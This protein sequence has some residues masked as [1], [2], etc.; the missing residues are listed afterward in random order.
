MGKRKYLDKLFKIFFWML[1][2]AFTLGVSLVTVARTAAV[3]V[4]SADNMTVSLISLQDSKY[5]TNLASP[6]LHSLCSLLCQHILQWTRNISRIWTPLLILYILCSSC[7]IN[8]PAQTAEYCML[9]WQQFWLFPGGGGG[10]REHCTR[11][12][13]LFVW[14]TRKVKM[15]LCS[16]KHHDNKTYCGAEIKI[17][18]FLII[19]VY[20]DEWS[21]TRSGLFNPGEGLLVRV[22]QETELACEPFWTW[23]L[24]EEFLP[25]S[26]IKPQSSRK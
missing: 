1:C 15:S 17:H 16:I 13:N 12:N 21:I 23:W 4:Y 25:M 22:K 19:A 10:G 6:C 3:K 20:W 8:A 9:V 2:S 18:A 11:P 14:T 7:V 24:S 26:R 5:C